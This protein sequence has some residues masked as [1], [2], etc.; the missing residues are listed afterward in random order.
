MRFLVLLLAAAPTGALAWDDLDR[1]VAAQAI[2]NVMASE[3]PCGLA[4]D[5]GAIIA[6]IDATIPADDMEF[7]SMLAMMT[8]GAEVQISRMSASALTAH[9]RQIERVAVTYG[10]IQPE[11]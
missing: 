7:T 3:A 6:H 10:F 9:C 1:S 8:A 11:G 5:P 4:Y 2:G